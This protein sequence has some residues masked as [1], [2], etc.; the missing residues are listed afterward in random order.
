M[1]RDHNLRVNSR[2]T[3]PEDLA[4]IAVG[5]AADRPIHLAD[6][7]TIQLTGQVPTGVT[8]V[9]GHPGVLLR[10]TQQKGANT[11]AIADAITARLVGPSQPSA[12]RR[13]AVELMGRN[14]VTPSMMPSNAEIRYWLCKSV[15]PS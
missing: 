14:S 2:V 15:T 10:L 7:A 12:M 1:A 9:N 11:M 5:G 3:L 13:C 6:I 4:L 8:R